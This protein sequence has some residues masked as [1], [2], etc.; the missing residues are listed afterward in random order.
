MKVVHSSLLVLLG[1]A[2]TSLAS[3]HQVEHGNPEKRCACQTGSIL[4]LMAL[5]TNSASA[6]SYCSYLFEPLTTITIY[7]GT[8]TRTASTEVFTTSTSTS[9]ITE[10]G[11]STVY[12]PAA[13]TPSAIC[14]QPGNILI[15]YDLL[16]FDGISGEAC[17]Q[18]CLA[19]PAC[20]G[21]QYGTYESNPPHCALISR[22]FT[23]GDIDPGQSF[24][25][26]DRDCQDLLPS[27]CT[28]LA[29]RDFVPAPSYLTGDSPS[30][31]S[32]ACS[33]LVHQTKQV[34][35]TTLFEESVTVPVATST[36]HISTLTLTTLSAPVTE[37]AVTTVQ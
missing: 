27:Q 10:N 31:I 14:D 12:C 32:S 29:K 7:T 11:V 17:Q 3:P 5:P 36:S 37:T 19:D 34:K 18:Y 33:C 1:A 24:N 23:Q 26:Y 16:T 13:P 6:S 28:P 15:D 20:K 21:I 25:L 35:K 2:A 22:P 4:S 30:Q 8:S 9:T